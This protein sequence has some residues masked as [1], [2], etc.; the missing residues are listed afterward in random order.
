[1]FRSQFLFAMTLAASTVVLPGCGAAGLLAPFI[2]DAINAIFDDDEKDQVPDSTPIGAA[3][4]LEIALGGRFCCDPA[5]SINQKVS[6]V[7]IRHTG[8]TGT[9]PITYEFVPE[10]GSTLSAT[11]QS[12]T[13]S[14]GESVNIDITAANC[15][16][17]SESFRMR[18]YFVGEKGVP[19]R[20]VTTELIIA[21]VCADGAALLEAFESLLPGEPVKQN[22]LPTIALVNFAEPVKHGDVSVP[23]RV[24]DIPL[25]QISYYGALAATLDAG[26]LEDAFT[27][28]SPVFPLGGSAAGNVFRASTPA[29]MNA[30]A[31]VGIF[32]GLDGEFDLIDTTRYWRFVVAVDHDGDT[33]NN[34]VPVAQQANDP[35]AG[36]DRWYVLDFVPGN[37]WDLRLMDGSSVT[38]QELPSAVRVI[39]SGDALLFV[40][41]RSEISGAGAGFRVVS[42]TH[43]GDGGTGPSH[44]WSGDHHPLPNL[45]AVPD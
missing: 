11:P 1:M 13:L 9:D 37:G 38:P 42:F 2:D 12:G 29:T 33:N 23:D 16:F 39:Q 28:A 21:N 41:P 15:D 19:G 45:A 30:G 10:S 20:S 4:D 8:D 6:I 3:V 43:T 7:T 34:F 18:T 44:D 5:N 32:F 35:L 17:V 14:R 22:L 40:I 31:Y 26:D 25:S 36:T 27:G 24:P